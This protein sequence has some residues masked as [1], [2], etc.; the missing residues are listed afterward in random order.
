MQH[1]PLQPE[2]QSVHFIDV[3]LPAGDVFAIC[4][5]LFLQFQGQVVDLLV[6]V[7]VVLLILQ[8]NSTRQSKYDLSCCY[9]GKDSWETNY[10]RP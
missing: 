2:G 3:F 1:A 10:S 8:Q 4:L 7:S 9:H 5:F 6:K